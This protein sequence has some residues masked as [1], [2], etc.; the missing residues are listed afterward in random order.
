M[1]SKNGVQERAFWRSDANRRVKFRK[2][3]DYAEAA[4]ELLD[5]SVKAPLRARRIPG[6]LVSGGFDSSAV[7]A[8][9]AVQCAP[10]ELQTYTAIPCPS[11]SIEGRDGWYDSEQANV[12]SLAAQYPN[13]KPGFYH[14]A[15]PAG[16]EYDPTPFFVAGARNFLTVNHVGWFDAAYRAAQADGHNCLLIGSMGNFTMSFDGLRAMSDFARAGRIDKLLRFVVPAVRYRAQI[17]LAADE[18]KHSSHRLAAKTT[19]HPVAA[20]VSGAR[21]VGQNNRDAPGVRQENRIQRG[22]MGGGRRR[23]VSASN[24]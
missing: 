2:P 13:I 5:R 18:V 16:F 1:V 23:D 24:Q 7:A 12:E 6:A 3:E 21:D 8:S 15:G 20:P 11:H 19:R 14:S 22:A 9:A 17:A 10:G 4:L